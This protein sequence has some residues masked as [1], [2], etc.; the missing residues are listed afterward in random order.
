MFFTENLEKIGVAGRTNAVLPP[1]LDL[2]PLGVFLRAEVNRI[3]I[4]SFLWLKLDSHYFRPHKFSYQLT[5][6]STILYTEEQKTDMADTP[7]DHAN[8]E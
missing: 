6:L 8:Q 7:V 5:A 2:R 4:N 3:D 1:S